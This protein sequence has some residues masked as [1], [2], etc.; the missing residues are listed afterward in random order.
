MNKP[1]T[2]YHKPINVYSF[3]RFTSA[4]F[5]SV[6][7]TVNLVYQ[8]TI[9]GL[10]PLQLVLVGA[11]LELTIFIAEIPT[12]IV[13]DVYSR[14][15]SVM[16]GLILIGLGFAV[17][18]LFPFFI[19][20]LLAQVIWGVGYTFVSGARE[21]WIADEMGESHAGKAFSRGTQMALLGSF[22][23]IG[24]S[25]ILANIDI[26][27]PI[28]LGGILYSFQSLYLYLYMPENNFEPTPTIERDTFSQMKEIF[29]SGIGLVKQNSVLMIVILT[30]LIF[31]MFSEGFDRL[32]TPYMIESFVFPDLWGLKSVTWF[33]I[34]AMVANGLAIIG[35]KYAERLTDT[36]NHQSTVKTLLISN[37]L[38]AISV[39]IFGLAST[40]TVAAVGFWLVS[41]FREV[42]NPIYDAWMN[43][44]VE[45]KVRATVFSICDQANSV[46]QIVGG[47]VLGLV[48]TMI[49]LRFSIVLAGLVLIPTLWLYYYSMTEHKKIVI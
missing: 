16:I 18:G 11:L 42:R 15:L 49:S 10:N 30:G 3:I 29:L 32:W 35:V 13:A 9:V 19:T 12:G 21:A 14:K 6:I 38:L 2:L 47:P 20:V 44:N 28:V 24:I 1:N 37:A 8:A 17:E 26:R 5:F 31:G 27:L 45:S 33:G 7:V 4:L 43:Q 41:M 23:G 48:A 22:I 36:N 34:F 25:M 39:I 40:F 46:G